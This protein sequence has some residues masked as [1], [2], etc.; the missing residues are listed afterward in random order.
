MDSPDAIAGLAENRCLKR[1]DRGA[2]LLQIGEQEIA[3]GAKFR[4]RVVLDI[5]VS[6]ITDAAQNCTTYSAPPLPA[7][8]RRSS[9][10]AFPPPSPAM[11]R[12]R[13]VHGI[14]QQP[15]GTSPRC[16]KMYEACHLHGLSV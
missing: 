2:Q 6:I 14:D 4:A 12:S 5:Q 8:L 16:I 15:G 9:R 10:Q 1:R 3:L 7:C 13:T 11:A